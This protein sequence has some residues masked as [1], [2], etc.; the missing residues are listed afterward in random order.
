MKATIPYIE[1]KFDEFNALCFEGSLPRPPFKLSNARTLLGQIRYKQKRLPFGRCHYSDFQLV[2][3]TRLELEECDLEDIILHEMIHLYILS[4][5]IRDTSPHGEV[6][7]RMMR[8]LN[9]R[10][11]RNIS[12]THHSTGNMKNEIAEALE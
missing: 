12:I 9:V 7:K 6:F 8:D 5:Q 2:V 3:S 1:R 11:N 10:F 4:N